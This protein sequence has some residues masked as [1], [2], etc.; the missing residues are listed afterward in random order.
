MMIAQTLDVAD[1]ASRIIVACLLLILALVVLGL[2]IWYYRRRWLDISESPSGTPWTLDD[3]EKMY[4]K[5]DI[6]EEEYRSMRESII[7][8]FTDKKSIKTDSAAA[9]QQT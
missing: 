4:E 2:I 3:L 1:L 6:N 9:P 7:A 5:G 8:A